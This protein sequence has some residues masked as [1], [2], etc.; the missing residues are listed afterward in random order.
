MKLKSL[1]QYLQ[2]IRDE[3][4]A[5]L[6][7]RGLTGQAIADIFSSELTRARVHQILNSNKKNEKL[8]VRK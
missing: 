6:D 4:I 3:L 8:L 2:V 1:P 5:E 7:K